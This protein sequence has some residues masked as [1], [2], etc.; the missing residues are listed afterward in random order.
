[1]IY[2]LKALSGGQKPETGCVCHDWQHAGTAGE[3]I[4]SFLRLYSRIRIRGDL[5][6]FSCPGFQCYTYLWLHWKKTHDPEL[7]C[8]LRLFKKLIY[9]GSKPQCHDF[10]IRNRSSLNRKTRYGISQKCIA[11]LTFSIMYTT[12]TADWSTRLNRSNFVKCKLSFPWAVFYSSVE[13][14]SNQ[15]ATGKAPT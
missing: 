5:R 1:M 15:I 13:E 3:E 10:I 11:S 7:L 12:L 9:G 8:E 2:C 4:T 6:S 14:S